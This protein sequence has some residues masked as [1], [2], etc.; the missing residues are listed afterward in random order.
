MSFIRITSRRFRNS[1]SEPAGF[2]NPDHR[3][4]TLKRTA[5]H[6]SAFTQLVLALGL[7][8]APVAAKAATKI[9]DTVDV[10]EDKKNATFVVRFNEPIRYVS[11]APKSRGSVIQVQLRLVGSTAEASGR[12]QI[13]RK[14]SG[15]LPLSGVTLENDAPQGPLLTLRFSRNVRFRIETGADFRSI[16][17]IVPAAPS[18]AKGTA[19]PRRPASQPATRTP[20][21]RAAARTATVNLKHPYVIN[22]MSTVRAIPPSALPRAE[23]VGGYRLYTATTKK[24]G[25]TWNRLRLGFFATSAAANAFLEQ[26]LRRRYPTAWVAKTPLSERKNSSRHAV[27]VAAA[28]SRAASVQS[29]SPTGIPA[30]ENRMGTLPAI[31]KK[32]LARVVEEARKAMTAK[33]YSRAIQLYTMLLQLPE[34][35]YR[36]EAQEFLG[37]ARERNGQTAHAIAEYETYLRLYPEGEGAD[38]VQQRLAGLQTARAKPRKPL[39]GGRTTAS[40]SDWTPQV[41][42]S[43]SQYFDR[44][45][46]FTD[47]QG[48]I[49]NQSNVRSDLDVTTRVRTDTVD[50][51][52]RFS[53]GLRNDVFPDRK[54][55]NEGTVSSLYLDVVGRK[56]GLSTRLGRQT[57]NSGGVL[58]RFD[59]GIVSYRP[60][61]LLA[62]NIVGGFPVEK[63]VDFP[64]GTERYFYGASTDLGP[65]YDHWSGNLFYI[66][67]TI[68]GINDRRAVGGEARYVTAKR[69]AF[70]LVDYDIGY[71]ALNTALFT[72]NWRFPTKTTASLSLDYRKSP[73]LTTK[74][75]EQGQ[76]VSS[77]WQ[78][79]DLFTEDKIRDLAEDRTANSKSAMIGASHPLSD[80]YQ[81]SG[82]FR[83]SEVSGTPSSGGVIGTPGTGA[84]FFGSLQLIAAGLLS[85]GDINIFGL[86]YN[87]ASS[88]NTATATI[89]SRFPVTRNFR[90]NP[91]LRAD[92]RHNKTTASD[93]FRLVPAVRLNYR[94][95]RNVHLEFQCGGEWVNDQLSTG[96]ENNF[97]Y[98]VSAG[99]RWD[100]DF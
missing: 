43:V 24:G 83:V 94:F 67:Q 74:N 46:S 79:L 41:Y 55:E 75:A 86:S 100:F 13:S 34:H 31:S 49:V 96:T 39:R 87:N 58:G 8:F 15:A 32:R 3:R 70:T 26:R 92:Y 52:N 37:L 91:K 9:L 47:A 22:L 23:E 10:T 45:E 30:S 93:R 14:A 78:M 17:V 11:H 81:V 5:K 71:N 76:P 53:G 16:A 62:L 7:A 18:R 48:R 72:G 20:S 19:E 57:R 6:G 59:G 54:A 2:P 36:K 90:L 35:E 73:L 66:E 65:F 68:E 51:R 28:A 61:R 89:N 12:E 38:R 84:E 40:K 42:G 29:R 95:R 27:S 63:T 1:R 60:V 99:Y 25:K 98:F 77:M 33:Q 4:T 64:T 69:S 85:S 80:K 88:A 56:T 82:E 44:D 50:I 97:G 21:K